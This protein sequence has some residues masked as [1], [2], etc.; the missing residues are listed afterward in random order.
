M[1]QNQQPVVFMVVI[2][3]NVCSALAYRI[4]LKY[5]YNNNFISYSNT[6]YRRWQLH[7][8]IDVDFK[9]WL[10]MLPDVGM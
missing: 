2:V 7:T 3:C 10:I 5:G 1:F 6:Q 9:I 8:P 4:K